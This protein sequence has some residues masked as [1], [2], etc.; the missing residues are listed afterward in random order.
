MRKASTSGLTVLG[1]PGSCLPINCLIIVP[2]CPLST[3]GT[4][5]QLPG[6]PKGDTGLPWIPGSLSSWDLQKETLCQGCQPS[7]HR[8]LAC[9][10]P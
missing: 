4:R 6:A 8:G 9:G 7:G 3:P 10:V 1:T 5:S 2:A